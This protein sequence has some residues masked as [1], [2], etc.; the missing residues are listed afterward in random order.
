M[1][2]CVCSNGPPCLNRLPPRVM[3]VLVLAL[4]PRTR[5]RT[6][7][8]CVARAR[9]WAVPTSPVVTQSM[10][11]T[12]PPLNCQTT[13]CPTGTVLTTVFEAGCFRCSCMVAPTNPTVVPATT[14]CPPLTC[15]TS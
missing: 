14:V 12:C 6:P 11:S 4:L 10:Q 8:P 13:V 15:P 9:A 1:R 5:L 2:L 7:L 3:P